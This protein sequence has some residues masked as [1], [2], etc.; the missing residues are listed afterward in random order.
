M[1]F[2]KWRESKYIFVIDL[3]VNSSVLRRVAPT[4][5]Q[6]TAQYNLH[7]WRFFFFPI[8]LY[9]R[10]IYS[11]KYPLWSKAKKKGQYFRGEFS[12]TELQIWIIY[13]S[14]LKEFGRAERGDEV[15][16]TK[17]SRRWHGSSQNIAV[18]TAN[19]SCV[20]LAVYVEPRPNLFIIN[21]NNTTVYCPR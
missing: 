3:M 18:N 4:R 14:H 7:V 20:C 13:H 11:L 17:R 21:T 12:D 6:I 19:R 15:T 8:F 5:A 16:K 1:R 9:K 2:F 10:K